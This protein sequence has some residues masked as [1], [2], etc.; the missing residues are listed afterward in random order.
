MG[1]YEQKSKD[2]IKRWYVKA[3]Y[4]DPETGK[5]AQHCKRGFTNPK[6]AKT[7]R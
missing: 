5:K 2:G 7:M 6:D 1:V 3:N 4:W